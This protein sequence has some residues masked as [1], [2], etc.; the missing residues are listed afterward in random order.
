MHAKQFVA[1]I[2]GG[3]EFI[4]QLKALDEVGADYVEI[5]IPFSDPVADGPIIMEAGQAAIRAGMTAQKIFDQLKTVNGQLNTRYLL[6]TYYHTIETYGEA[7]FMAEAEAAGVEGLI[8]PDMPFEYIEQLKARY[9]ERQLKFISL[10]AMT[11]APE[12]RQRIAQSAEGFIYTITMN[13]ITGQNGNFH[14]ELK[15][16]ILDIKQH[17]DVPVMA[18]FGIRTPEHVQ[19]IIEV[20]DGVIIGSE[21][22][23]RF[24]EEGIEVTK[25]YLARVREALGKHRSTVQ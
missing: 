4:A 23:R 24:N 19:E 1:Y 2:M 7:A 13:Q 21:I 14:P 6:M 3:P 25:Q 16:N 5:G 15:Q 9:P 12:R 11:A 18:G 22:V 20:A 8:I 10:I 17:S